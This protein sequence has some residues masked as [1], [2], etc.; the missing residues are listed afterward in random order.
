[1]QKWHNCRH[2]HAKQNEGKLKE[3]LMMSLPAGDFFMQTDSDYWWTCYKTS[4][5]RGFLLCVDRRPCLCDYGLFCARL[6]LAFCASVLKRWTYSRL[7]SCDLLLCSPWHMSMVVV[8][9]SVQKVNPFTFVL[10]QVQAQIIRLTI[11][12]LSCFRHGFIAHQDW[13]CQL[14]LRLRGLSNNSGL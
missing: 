14:G 7:T 8:E 10:L 3:I 4:Q 6:S 2:H 13:C 12:S 11:V 9:L 5:E 1:M